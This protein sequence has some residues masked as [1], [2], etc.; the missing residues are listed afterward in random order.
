MR[1]CLRMRSSASGSVS[2]TSRAA[3]D[4]M[5]SFLEPGLGMRA[6]ASMVGPGIGFRRPLRVEFIHHPQ[7]R[8][9][10]LA[11]VVEEVAGGIFRHVAGAEGNADLGWQQPLYRGQHLR[12]AAE[13]NQVIGL[14]L[15]GQFR[16][17]NLV[18]R[19]AA[20]PGARGVEGSGVNKMEKRS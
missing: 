6:P 14:G 19:L 17:P 5:V 2:T 1:G 18:Q 10:Q 11:V 3:Y 15:P 8:G 13:L 7:E 12:V 20:F 16:V 4:E 9:L